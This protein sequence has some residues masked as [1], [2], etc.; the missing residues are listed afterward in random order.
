MAVPARKYNFE[1]IVQ[2]VPLLTPGEKETLEIMLQE[3][4]HTEIIQRRK[5]YQAE[6]KQK[7]TYTTQEV[8]ND[9]DKTW[10]LIWSS[11]RRK[12]TEQRIICKGLKSNAG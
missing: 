6:K 3:D 12:E 1:N 10:N 11:K 8:L 9:I 7:K 4:L 5:K 2:M